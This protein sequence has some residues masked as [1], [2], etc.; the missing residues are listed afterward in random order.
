MN[1]SE[2]ITEQSIAFCS[3]DVLRINDNVLKGFHVRLGKLKLDNSRLASFYFFYRVGGRNGRQVNYF[4]GN[5]EQMDAGLARRIAVQIE[6]H[7][8]AGK[9]VQQMKFNAEKG[10]VKFKEFWRFQGEEFVLVKYKNGSDIVSQFR[11]HIL[12]KIG[13]IDLEKL[14]HRLIGLRIVSP[15]IEEN[16]L[17]TARQLVSVLKQV[18]EKAVLE[19]YLQE[20]PIENFPQLKVSRPVKEVKENSN[21]LTGAQIKGIYY[22]ASKMSNRSVYLFTLRLQ[23]LSA[24][25]LS[26]ICRTFR[27]DIKGNKWLLRDSSGKLSGKVIPLDGP[28]K[29]LLKQG[30]KDHTNAQSLYLIPGKGKRII[31]DQSMDPKSLAKLQQ[32][33][34][35]DVHGH[36]RTMTQLL[37]D[38]EQAMIDVQVPPLVVAYLFHKKVES[39]LKLA[40]DDPSVKAG[41]TIWYGG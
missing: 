8:K 13:S 18:L 38:I 30:V 28:L 15:L 29:A 32:K 2:R 4:I 3:A 39:Y 14:S 31:A 11:R 37:G 9:D 33:F 1:I 35:L 10:G 6:P 5:S 25:S 34:I 21:Q 17:G 7:V 19:K 26:M 24:Q 27:Q 22:R 23:I 40:P 12:P 36:K 20:Q 41:L 16:K